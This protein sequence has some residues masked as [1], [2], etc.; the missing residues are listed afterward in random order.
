[1]SINRY[2]KYLDLHVIPEELLELPYEIIHKPHK[3]YSQVHKSYEYFQTRNVSKELSQY[4]QDIFKYKCSIQ[5]QII[6]DRIH[7][8]KDIGRTAA[9]NYLI[10]TGGDNVTTA[11]YDDN[12]NFLCEEKITLNKWH[13]LK[14]DMFHCVHGITDY[15]IAVSV[16]IIGYVWNSNIHIKD[17]VT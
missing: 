8:H 7:I 12:K 2:L 3:E 14:T 13:R 4:L 6:K 5:Y 10:K 15:R 11:I 1:M 16:E 17:V 9:F